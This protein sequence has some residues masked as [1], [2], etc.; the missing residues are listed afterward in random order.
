MGN[1]IVG[2]YAVYILF[3]TVATIFVAKTLFSHSKIFMTTIFNG[4][5]ELAIATNKLFEM[6]FFLLAFGLGLWYLETN[7]IISDY[8]AFFEVASMKMGG[9]TLFLGI[10]LLC[11]LYLFFRGMKH[12][13]R[14]AEAPSYDVD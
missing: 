3:I 5:E 6:G 2:V 11:N 4:R 7:T 9:F 14:S 12:R 10:L 8:R 1:L 13:N